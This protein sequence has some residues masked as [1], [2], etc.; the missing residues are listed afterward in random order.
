M[1]NIHRAYITYSVGKIIPYPSFSFQIIL[2]RIWSPLISYSG[3]KI[4]KFPKLDWLL[5]NS[6]IIKLEYFRDFE[7][8]KTKLIFKLKIWYKNKDK[9]GERK[10]YS[11]LEQWSKTN[12]YCRRK[13]ISKRTPYG[14]SSRHMPFLWGARRSRNKLVLRALFSDVS[15]WEEINSTGWKSWKAL[16]R[17]FHAARN[18]WKM[19]FQALK[20]RFRLSFLSS[21]FPTLVEEI[22]RFFFDEETH[23]H[24]SRLVYF[25]HKMIVS[26]HSNSNDCFTVYIVRRI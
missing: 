2:L 25:L 4:A 23:G 24:H 11:I 6:S 19:R 10:S 18:C 1:G 8:A 5:R 26:N 7:L 14:W 21:A 20:L 16:E 15:Q 9:I 12:Y 3:N 17:L 22:W 13:C